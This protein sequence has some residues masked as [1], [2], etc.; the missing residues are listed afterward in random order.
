MKAFVIRSYGPNAQFELTDVLKPT[1]RPG[2]VLIQV[3]A[4]SLNPVD[5]KIRTLDV[6][7]APELPAVLHGDVAG[8]VTE[9][10]E[11]VSTFNV[12][13]EVYG[14]AGGVKGQ[15]GA[16][17]EYMLADA[18]LLAHKPQ[19]LGFRETAALPLVS[20]T[21]WEG[22]I[23]RARVQP[24]Q[25]VLIHAAAGGVGHVA[26]QLAKI[27]GTTVFTTAS[28]KEKTNIGIRLGA[29]EVINYHQES[30]QDYTKRL[31]EGKGFDIVFD[32][33]GGLNID[34]SFEATA[35]NGQVITIVS[36]STHDLSLMHQRGLT[37]HVVFMLLPMLTGKGR[38]H[39]GDILKQIATWVDEGKLT[40]LVDPT[41]FA[42]KEIN[43]AHEYFSTGNH[44]GKIVI[45]HPS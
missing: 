41:H 29:K 22:L 28:T 4:T 43:A 24:G 11:G 23:D 25:Q 16:L 21:A 33:L 1:I 31:T 32:T 12:G 13:D 18:Q 42:L 20:I 45:E 30:P 9:V 38:A 39:H 7:I 26:L 44:T 3:K 17:A 10:G 14:C 6:P 2:H 34:R 15:G 8:V 35:P 27:Q 36:Q 19:T 5:W 40:P 37:L